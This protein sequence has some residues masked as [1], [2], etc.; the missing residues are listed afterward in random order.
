MVEIIYIPKGL[1]YMFEGHRFTANAYRIDV[2]GYQIDVEAHE[3]SKHLVCFA[4]WDTAKAV[5]ALA[6]ARKAVSL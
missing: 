5:E 4:G 1:S 2:N 3:A 6:K